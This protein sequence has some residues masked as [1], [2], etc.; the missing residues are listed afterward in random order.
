MSLNNQ[1]IIVQPSSS[2]HVESFVQIKVKVTVEVS[3]DKLV[4]LVFTLGMEILE[5]VQISPNVQ[6]VRCENVRLPLDQVLALHPRDLTETSPRLDVDPPQSEVSPDGGEDVRQ[7]GAGSLDTISVI[8]PSLPG[9]SI[10][11]ELLQV[12]VEVHV[13]S[14]EMSAEQT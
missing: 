12:V 6:T 14:T 13:S 10:A 3:P 11:V 5:L 1:Q 4:D 8:N 2:E 9:L 7:V